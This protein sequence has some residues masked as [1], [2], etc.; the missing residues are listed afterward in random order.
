V[1]TGADAEDMA[2]GVPKVRRALDPGAVDVGADAAG[3]RPAA[4]R[5]LDPVLAGAADAAGILE[6]AADL[7]AGL[8][9]V[10]AA[11]VVWAD[12]RRPQ[13]VVWRGDPGGDL[14]ALAAWTLHRATADGSTAPA[15]APGGSGE[16]WLVVP[17]RPRDGGPGP[18]AGARGALGVL[19]GEPRVR[20]GDLDAQLALL[21]EWLGLAFGRLRAE[22]EGLA[23]LVRRDA[24][25]GAARALAGRDPTEGLARLLAGVLRS[26]EATWAALYEWEPTEEVLVLR[27]AAPGEAATALPPSLPVDPAREPA[28]GA[29]G[30]EQLALAGWTGPGRPWALA[31]RPD[32]QQLAG[33]LVLEGPGDEGA[34]AVRLEAL[35]ALAGLALARARLAREVDGLAGEDP[36]T[37]LPGE[38]TLERLLRVRLAD[39][40]RRGLPL[41]VL[42]VA[43]E[44][45]V[46]AAGRVDPALVEA[47]AAR[48]LRAIL[49][50]ADL[51]GR[52][53][54]GLVVVL[55]QVGSLPGAKGVAERV[56][57]GL[58][59]PL[60]GEG[61]MAM[62]RPRVGLVLAAG[63]REPLEVVAA[64]LAGVAEARRQGVPLVMTALP[65]GRGPMPC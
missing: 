9:G 11:L 43:V 20:S 50:G 23:R 6:A 63:P 56:L 27:A 15:A 57:S 60:P 59:E 25:L 36:V 24:L 12:G 34:R 33:A 1:A 64:A 10:R 16:R 40:A 54:G 29:S 21:G 47:A 28:V 5:S 48:R 19:L 51:V 4:S 37:G 30:G 18:G 52:V 45:A 38:G 17:A 35:A 22:A 61:W 7:A 39:A 8:P 55:S 2:S 13:R 14:E 26:E 32:G 53:P 42:A 3:R 31:L 41:V 49:R 62:V 46:P 58:A 44:Q 65:G